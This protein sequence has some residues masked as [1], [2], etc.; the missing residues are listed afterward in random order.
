MDLEVSVDSVYDLT[1]EELE[2]L[3]GCIN[4]ERLKQKRLYYKYC[5]AMFTLAYR[6]LND[7]DEANDVLQDAF[8]QVFQK[9]EQFRKQSSLGAW[10]KTIV[11]RT[12]IKHLKS[13]KLFDTFQQEK[14]D[15]SDFI[16]NDTDGK[17]LEKIILSLPDGYRT[18]FILAE[19]EGYKHRE[20]AEILNISEGT[21]KSQLF[22][23][24]RILKEKLKNEWL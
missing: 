17:I 18:I 23:A 15:T 7:G 3:E 9:I 10:I 2:L 8:L 14:H 16:P 13:Q 6:I 21:S 22:N 5:D 1:V 24:K 12:A 4:K 19:V 20:I 11:V